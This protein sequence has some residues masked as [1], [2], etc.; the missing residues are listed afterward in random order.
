MKK[1]M[2]K[3]APPTGTATTPAFASPDASQSPE[4]RALELALMRALSRGTSDGFTQAEADKVLAWA[5]ETLTN[6]TLL[7]LAL[8]HLLVI[9]F[10]E[11]GR[12]LFNFPV[13]PVT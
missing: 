4:D 9:S 8:D 11:D 12:M 10:G 7:E 2:Y 1:L 5:H 3:Q 6:A 13:T